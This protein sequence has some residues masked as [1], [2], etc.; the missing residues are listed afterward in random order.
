MGVLSPSGDG[1]LRIYLKTQTMKLHLPKLLRNSVLACITAV[2]GIATTT[3]GTA[4]FTGGVVAFAL[5]S[6]QAAADYVWNGG[7]GNKTGDDWKNE[8]S[9]NMVDGSTWNPSNLD[10]I[11]GPG[12]TG[13]NMW[14]KVVID[15]G[16]EGV[17]FG[18]EDSRDIPLEGWA[19]KYEL[20]NN[21]KLYANMAKLQPDNNNA[22]FTVRNNSLLDFQMAGGSFQGTSIL[23]VGENSGIIFRMQ[24]TQSTAAMN[25]TM[26]SSTG[27]VKFLADSNINHT[28]AITLNPVLG[29]LNSDWGSMDLGITAK[30]VTLSNLTVNPGAAFDGWTKVDTQI[31][32]ANYAGFGNCYSIIKNAEGKY[33]LTYAVLQEGSSCIWNGGELSWANDTAFSNKTFSA[34][35]V[36]E[37]SDSDADVVLQEDIEATAVIIDDGV[38]VS[39]DGNTHELNI[40]GALRLDGTLVLKSDCLTAGATE[41]GDNAEIA[42]GADDAAGKA[43][44]CENALQSLG[45]RLVHFMLAPFGGA[46]LGEHAR[47]IGA[48][49]CHDVGF[50]GAVFLLG[51]PCGTVANGV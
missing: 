10:S 19:P 5:S 23:T 30:N 43:A 51:E 42:E 29:E 26:E 8:S 46:R 48:G 28:G 32:E 36:V 20:N 24:Q 1:I 21:A 34:G 50:F 2:A 12:T 25:I 6:Q 22:I 18:S 38:T 15:G 41:A 31:T 49:L 44:L 13:S 16:D 33:M 45:E 7:S 27:Y 3:V 17:V 35:S 9:W 39:L 14:D 40:T 37:F 11:N 47:K 4:T